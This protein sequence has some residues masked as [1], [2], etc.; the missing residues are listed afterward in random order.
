VSRFREK[1]FYLLLWRA[2][3]VALLALVLSA[4]WRL[5]LR[6]ALLTG[7]NVALLFAVGLILWSGWLGA[8]RIEWTN[9]WRILRPDER[10][11]GAAGRTVAYHC[12][13]GLALRFAKGSSAV[14]AA[15]SVSALLLAGG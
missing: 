6:G 5:D 9:A 7:A 8:E 11:A 2:V 3:L 4:T 12:L 10:P 14:A 15:M 13:R 1:L